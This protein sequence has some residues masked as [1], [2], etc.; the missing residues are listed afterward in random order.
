M[1]S[2][3][4]NNLNNEQKNNIYKCLNA[5]FNKENIDFFVE[6]KIYKIYQQQREELNLTKDF[7][8]EKWNVFQKIFN[9]NT[10]SQRKKEIIKKVFDD[11]E[12]I[13][14]KIILFNKVD[15]FFNFD[16]GIA[17]GALRDMLLMDNPK[18]KDID[19]ILSFK[20]KKHLLEKYFNF[21]NN[22]SSKD[23]E[24]FMQSVVK[25]ADN[26]KKFGLPK[27]ETE[28]IFEMHSL[29]D[30]IKEYLMRV[31]SLIINQDFKSDVFYRTEFKNTANLKNIINSSEYSDKHLNGVIKIK[32]GSL[33][34]D[35]DILLT[36]VEIDYYLKAFDYSICK[37]MSVFIRD[38]IFL[39]KKNDWKDFIKSVVLNDEIY[40]D[41]IKKEISFNV[42]R[43]S[44][45]EIESSI[46]NHYPRIKQKYPN[47]KLILKG[48][49]NKKGDLINAL[50]LTLD[51]EEKLLVNNKFHKEIA[52]I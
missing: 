16:L 13:S 45:A 33:N 36:S 30:M 12:K 29:D 20:Y 43:F 22:K 52:K 15:D 8:I 35:I 17:G 10:F 40:E 38:G 26:F 27:L 50:N 42:D 46:K 1:L 3:N 4:F 19:L 28:S 2:N 48:D 11:I 47:F 5:L 18:V 25:T 7:S 14:E 44:K 9:F 37:I 32:D 41:L 24:L 34:F 39:L 49:M 21:G 23:K 31:V 51:L 6:K